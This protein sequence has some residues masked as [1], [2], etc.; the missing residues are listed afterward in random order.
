MKRQVL[1]TLSTAALLATAAGCTSGSSSPASTDVEGKN[2]TGTVTVWLMDDAQKSWPDLVQQVNDEF[3]AKYPNVQ[4]KLSYH[5]WEEKISDLDAAFAS[6]QAPDVVELGNTETLKYIVNGS[7]LKLE[8]GTFD[9]SDN[10]IKG[11]ADTC[12]YKETL[13]CVPYYTG[14]RVSIYNSKM[15]QDGAGIAELPQ[16]EDDMLAALDKVAAKYKNSANYSSL[17]LPGNYWYAAM[18]YVAAYGGS[19]AKFDA[20]G[21]WHGTLHEPKSQQGLQ[22]FVDLVRKYNK[23]GDYKINESDQAKVLGHEKAGLIYANG[24]ELG[25]ATAPI[26]GT[27][28][29]EGSL[30]IAAMP[31]PNGKPLPSFIGGSDLA[32]TAKSQNAKVAADWVRMFTSTKSEQLLA[33]KDTLPNNLVQLA[34]L[35]NKP[36]T[37]AA[38][39]AVQDA[40]FTPLAPGWG[41][42]EKQNVLVNMLNAI[43][44]GKSVDQATKEADAQ[45][46]ELINNAG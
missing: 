32:V 40:W 45:I 34:P 10:W 22:H 30:K 18:S 36:A 41:T 37:S 28:A 3:A 25:I 42:I 39:N 9:N 44:A 21:N 13:Y 17:Y 46:D 12:T 35:K 27:P 23:S 2:A 4:I 38:A 16:N 43:F 14:A 31:G 33:D 15:L 29:L 11:L 8:R 1:A 6:G 26:T 7:L 24:W 5:K 19:I 20:G